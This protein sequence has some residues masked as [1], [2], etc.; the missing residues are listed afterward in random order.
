[1]AEAIANG[2]VVPFLGAGAA[3]CDRPKDC[4]WELG[5]YV[6]SGNEL[7]G[8]LADVAKRL[9]YEPDPPN[10]PPDL[11]RVSQWVAVMAGSPWLYRE[12]R[13]VFDADY[14]PTSLH[15]FLATLPAMLRAKGYPPHQLIV[16]TNYDDL[17]ERSFKD[18]NE[19]YDLTTYDAEGN[20]RG[21][22]WH[23]P[24]GGE[25]RVIETPNSYV[26]VSPEKRT[27]ILKIHGAVD[28]IQKER[29]SYVITEDH[30]ID[31][32]TRT[33]NLLPV[34]LL[35][36]LR[37]SYLLFLGYSLRDWNLRVML[38]RMWG[39]QHLHYPSWAI[40]RNVQEVDEK[41]WSKQHVTIFD[42][43]LDEFIGELKKRVQALPHAGGLG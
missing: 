18:A 8:R 35:A 22:F 28:R 12:L 20:N 2:D 24:H 37:N 39:E 32:L 40:Q 10:S 6:P 36:K 34:K 13:S 27:V 29:D 9:G 19:P 38:Q 14:R 43:A 11:L 17:L 31:Y 7:A 4:G 25:P 21:K 15:Q 5:K 23:C 42:M 41:F 1:M 26:D 30:Y 3:L 16:T 33:E